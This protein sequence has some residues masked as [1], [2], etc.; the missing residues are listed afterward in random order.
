MLYT[1]RILKSC[2]IIMSNVYNIIAVFCI[3]SYF[4]SVLY[5]SQPLTAW[6]GILPFCFD[7]T[8]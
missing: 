3:V 7:G 4:L 5:I 2:T 6:W 1:M 8:V